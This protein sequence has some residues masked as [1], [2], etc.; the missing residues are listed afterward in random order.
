MNIALWLTKPHHWLWSVFKSGVGQRSAHVSSR[1]LC[2]RSISEYCRKNL[3]CWE[4][5]DYYKNIS[6]PNFPVCVLLMMSK[7][8]FRVWILLTKYCSQICCTGLRLQI[9]VSIRSAGHV[10]PPPASLSRPMMAPCSLSLRRQWRETD[11]TI[12]QTRVWSRAVNTHFD[13]LLSVKVIVDV[14]PSGIEQRCS[15]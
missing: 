4:P 10:A 2:R 3:Y 8:G 11:L 15:I 5:S 12:F 14:N 13:S 9:P 7:L 1:H 6:H